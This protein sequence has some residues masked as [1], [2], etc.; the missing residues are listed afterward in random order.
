MK[1][2]WYVRDPEDGLSVYDTEAEAKK[3]CEEILDEE[4]DRAAGDGWRDDMGDLE[5]GEMIVHQRAT[6]VEESPAPEG[7]AFDSFQKWELR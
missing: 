3:R 2:Q 5:W 1:T 4:Q 7:S 6:M